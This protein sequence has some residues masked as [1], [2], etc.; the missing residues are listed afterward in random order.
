MRQSKELIVARIIEI[1]K[2]GNSERKNAE[3]KN[4]DSD[5]VALSN[6]GRMKERQKLPRYKILK[7]IQP[8]R[9]EKG[10]TE[11]YKMKGRKRERGNSK[12]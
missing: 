1:N 2:Q 10:Q 4:S 9:K 12:K 8:Q 3:K 7:K 6:V 5:Q 11:R